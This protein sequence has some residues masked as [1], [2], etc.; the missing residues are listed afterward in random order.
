MVSEA[1]IISIAIRIITPDPKIIIKLIIR[2]IMRNDQKFLAQ[3]P[4]N[5]ENENFPL[6]LLIVSKRPPV[7]KALIIKPIRK[8]NKMP[9]DIKDT[10]FLK[11]GPRS[12]KAIRLKPATSFSVIMLVP[13][14][15]FTEIRMGN[16]I[17]AIRV[18]KNIHIIKTPFHDFRVRPKPDLTES[19]IFI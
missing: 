17:I 18:R 19:Y 7:R 11:T 8:M 14:A 3:A 1:L 16:A 2:V 13:N 4:K 5:M 6:S 15:E 12:V 9:A 10:R